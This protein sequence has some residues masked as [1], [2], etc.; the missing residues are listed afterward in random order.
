MAANPASNSLK[1]TLVLPD[2]N[3]KLARK[4][5]Q[6]AIADDGIVLLI[7]L[8]SDRFVLVKTA[9]R[10]AGAYPNVRR[11]VWVT[12]PDL[13]ELQETLSDLTG[14]QAKVVVVALGFTDKVVRR[15]KESDPLDALSLEAAFFASQASA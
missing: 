10:R 5:L 12:N 3:G 14:N 6:G 9:D 13:A 11:V 7:I 4:L 15:L 1:F 8:G 2:D